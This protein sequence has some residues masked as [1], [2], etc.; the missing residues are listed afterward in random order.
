MSCV[1]ESNRVSGGQVWS[2]CVSRLTGAVALVLAI[3]SFATAAEPS[4]SNFIDAEVGRVWEREHVAPPPLANDGEFLRRLSLDLC[5]IIPAHDVARQFLDDADPEKRA[6]LI[7]RLLDDPRYA[8]HQAD[9]WDM[10]LFGRNP[11]GYD[12]PKRVGFQNWLRTV[13]AANMP[14]DQFVTAL[15]RAEGNT[16]EQGAPMYLVQYARQ[17][18]DAA[19]AVTQ[20]LLGIQLQC[21][22]CHDHPFEDWTQRD[23]YGMAAFFTRNW[24][25]RHGQ[26]NMLDRIYLGEMNTGELKFVG[27]A[28]DAVPG[29]QGE[30]IKPKFLLGAA[31]EEPDL[32]AE[33]KNEK[34]P[35]DGQPPVPPKFS[36]KDKLA[37]WVT[38][39]S[40]PYFARAAVNRVW[41]QF[42]GRGLIHPVDNMSPSKKPSHPELLEKLTQEFVARKFDL[43]SLIREIC[44][45][46]T[47]QAASTGPVS[48]PFPQWFERART[49]PL[50]AEELLESWRVA[51]GYDAAVLQSGKKVEGRFHG[52]TWDYVKHFFGEPTNGVGDFQGGLQEHLYLN[53]GEIGRLLT[54]DKGS[55]LETVK[56]STE[57]AEVKV[58]RVFVS[59]LSRRP[60]DEE[61]S[62]M[63]EFVSEKENTVERWQEAVWTLMS[64]S[65]FRFNH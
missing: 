37:E 53:N 27:P 42:L 11:P 44:N 31:L 64:C 17:P 6:K 23:F 14:Y 61:R 65:E 51:T 45:S 18:E 1:D 47:Y 2:G 22:R 63:V 36:R 12:A 24:A 60:T 8:Q 33:F 7:D 56:S 41:A 5:G 40:N 52:V 32:S 34:Y 30:P 9:V 58:E 43:K 59:V 35:P 26:V 13:F 46:K 28:K 19:V 10:V 15:L 50:S 4:L 3:G 20:T 16:A 25:V 48:E 54:W 57:P 38:S 62:K 55:L 49:R 39:S 21:A 29:T